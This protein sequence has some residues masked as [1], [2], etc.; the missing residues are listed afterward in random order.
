M[1][2]LLPLVQT[3]K[4]GRLGVWL[5][6]LKASFVSVFFRTPS[7]KAYLVKQPKGL[8][9]DQVIKGRLQATLSSHMI[10]FGP[11]SIYF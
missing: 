1:E 8:I 2:R 6:P 9:E 3:L 11:Y 10:F 5:S 7:S 4:T